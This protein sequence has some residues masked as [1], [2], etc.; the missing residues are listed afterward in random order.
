MLITKHYGWATRQNALS[1]EG[2]Y[3]N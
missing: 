1:T 3:Y 2:P